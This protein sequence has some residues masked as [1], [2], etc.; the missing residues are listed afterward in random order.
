[1]DMKTKYLKLSNDL[2]GKVEIYELSS[3]ETYNRYDEIAKR[4]TD[5]V[6]GTRF[7]VL[8]K[9]P[10]KEIFDEKLEVK[11]AGFNPIPQYK[12]GDKAFCRFTNLQLTISKIE[13]GKATIKGVADSI[14]L[15][16]TSDNEQIKGQLKL[17][18]NNKQ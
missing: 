6:A 14:E 13:Y 12:S 3:A 18:L 9:I 4:T 5:E 8:L 17:N 1:M 15:V 10:E 7:N 2:L 16:S 11:V